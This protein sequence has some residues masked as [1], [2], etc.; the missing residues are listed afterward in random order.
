MKDNNRIESLDVIRGFAVLGILIMNIQSFS[1]PGPAY[2]NPMAYGDM[3]GGN[4]WVWI[5]SHVFADSK[6]MSLFSMLFGASILLISDNAEKKLGSSIGMHYRRNF[7]LL[8]IGLFHAYVMWQGD[9]LTPYAVIAFLVYP[10][11]KMKVRSLLIVGTLLFSVSS[12]LYLFTGMSIQYMPATDLAGLMS[13]WQPTVEQIQL[14][15]A[16]FTGTFSQQMEAR[17]EETIMMHTTVF[18][19]LF[20]WRISGLMLIGMALY[21]SGFFQGGFSKAFYTRTMLIAGVI[22]FALVVYGV[23]QNFGHEW[24]LEYSMFI[25]SQ[26]NYWGS[27]GVAIAYVAIMNLIIKS[28]ALTAIRIRLAAV[29]KLALTNY[30]S[31]TLLGTFIFYGFGLGLFGQIERSGQIGIVILIWVFQL[32]VSPIWLK[33]F[34]YGPAEWMWRSLSQMKWQAFRKG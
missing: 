11:R 32:V 3:A 20:L 27:L 17:V 26:Y 22:G 2:L 29:G 18:L 33:H 9:I 7:W 14:E 23:V 16:A 8:L 30:L 12:I 31:Q 10:M 13:G 19:I 24:S 6:F 21:K 5:V 15:I 34:H 28:G 4:R 25:G 1:M